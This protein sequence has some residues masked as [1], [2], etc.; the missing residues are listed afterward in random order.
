MA[1]EF[2]QNENFVK[3]KFLFSRLQGWDKIGQNRKMRL[4]LKEL[5]KKQKITQGVIAE[6][7]GVSIGS[8]SRY[9]SGLD[10]I[11]T[12]FLGD[13]AAAYGVSVLEIFE[14]GDIPLYGHVGAGAEILV[15]HE[16]HG[17]ETVTRPA[18]VSGDLAAVRV[19]GDSM[20]DKYY[21]GDILF[22]SNDMQAADADVV[23]R[24]CVVNLDDGRMM[25]K[26]VTRGKRFGTY[27][28]LSAGAEPIVDVLLRWAAPIRAVISNG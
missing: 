13:V 3:Q 18:G 21:P 19:A 26:K 2:A 1:E 14:P 25:V 7:L 23:G 17:G 8:I 12:K 9:E 22:Y 10:G 6:R 24:Y 5:R 28:L 27:T 15:S 11:S 4:R 16:S 20:V